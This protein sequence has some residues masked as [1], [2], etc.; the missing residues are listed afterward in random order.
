MKMSLE[1]LLRNRIIR[2]IKPDHKLATNSIVRA[3]RDIDTAKTFEKEVFGE[4]LV[5]GKF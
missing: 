5:L 2:R 1:E 3:N 4:E